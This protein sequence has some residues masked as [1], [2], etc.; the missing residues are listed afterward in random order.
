MGLTGYAWN[1]ADRKARLEQEAVPPFTC[2]AVGRC[3]G[4]E[5]WLQCPSGQLMAPTRCPAQLGGEKRKGKCDKASGVKS[6]QGGHFLGH[7]VVKTSLGW[8]A[9]IPH[10]SWPK[11]P[12][13]KTETIL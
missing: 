1:G 2:K 7:P 12:K 13:C 9:K 10:A 11:K 4:P 3:R 6:T 5:L 8:K